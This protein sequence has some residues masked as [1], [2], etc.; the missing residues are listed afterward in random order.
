MSDNYRFYVQK[1]EANQAARRVVA[2]PLR[3][4]LEELLNVVQHCERIWSIEDR[5]EKSR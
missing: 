3:R 5:I 4:Q 1:Q 2:H